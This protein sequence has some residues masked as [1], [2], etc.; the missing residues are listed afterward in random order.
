VIT[1]PLKQLDERIVTRDQNAIGVDEGA[2]NIAAG[3]FVQ[4]FGKLRM[5]GGLTTAEHHNIEA[6]I[7]SG[8]P[9]INIGQDEFQWNDTRKL[10]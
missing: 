1:V 7:L 8:E 6:A 5:Q 10:G 2:H 9:L 4:K 3:Q